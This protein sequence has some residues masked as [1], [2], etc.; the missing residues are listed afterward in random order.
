MTIARPRAGS[1]LAPVSE[2]GIES[3][4]LAAPLA[5]LI[6]QPAA[7]SAAANLTRRPRR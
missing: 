3:W 4:A 1:P 6:A 7:T 5:A 2:A